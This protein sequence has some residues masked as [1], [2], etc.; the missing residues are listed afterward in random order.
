MVHH[1]LNLR[2]IK[3]RNQECRLFQHRW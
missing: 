2:N 1:E 3:W